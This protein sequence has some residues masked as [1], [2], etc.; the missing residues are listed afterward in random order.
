MQPLSAY[1]LRVNQLDAG[2]LD[3]EISSLLR[4]QFTDIS[5][6]RT[7]A[8]D[9]LQPELEALLQALIWRYSIWMDAPTPGCQLQNLRHARADGGAV[10]PA[11]LRRGQKLALLAL[12]A[13]LPWL[14]VRLRGLAL[15]LEEAAPDGEATGRV[16]APQ[17]WARGAARWYLRNVASRLAAVH[18][19]CTAVNFIIFLRHGLFCNLSD[20]LLG[21]RLVHIDPAAH[22]QVAFEYMNRVMVWNGLSEFLMTVVPL[23]NL[24]NL[25]QAFARR[26]FPRAM[27]RTMGADAEHSCSLCGASPMTLPMRSDCGHVFCYFC[28][29]SEQMEQPQGATCPHCTKRIRNIGHAQ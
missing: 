19:V 26:L 15:A 3:S 10:A 9:R 22:R 14:A 20:R 5:L 6:W 7:A 2:R 29:A 27:L 1:T 21:I 4:Q 25:W 11:P 18:A 16:A 24:A 17:R 28:I 8:L 12:N 23:L 13:L